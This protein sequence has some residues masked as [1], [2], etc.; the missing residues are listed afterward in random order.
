ME[1]FRPVGPLLNDDLTVNVANFRASVLRLYK[2]FCASGH[3]RAIAYKSAW[4]RFQ[5]IGG[6]QRLQILNPTFGNDI[7]T[8]GD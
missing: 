7:C 1:Y 3:S 5:V 4:R 6:S 8:L 2:E